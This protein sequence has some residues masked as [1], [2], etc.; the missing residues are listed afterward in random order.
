[1]YV[2]IFRAVLRNPDDEYSRIAARLREL[3]LQQFNCIEFVAAMEGANEIALSYWHSEADI[4][5]WKA[6]AEHAMAQELG[7]ERWYEA[8]RVQVAQIE[9]DYAFG[10]KQSLQCYWPGIAASSARV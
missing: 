3:A 4:K 8:Y 5:A 2:V 10:S 7:R 1:M 9:R 6:Y